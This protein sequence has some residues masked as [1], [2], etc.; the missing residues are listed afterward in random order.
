MDHLIW[1]IYPEMKG[2]KM[3]NKPNCGNI[4]ILIGGKEVSVTEPTVTYDQIMTYTKNGLKSID[5]SGNFPFI[6]FNDAASEPKNGLL[7]PGQEV[8]VSQDD[9]TKFN[10]IKSDIYLRG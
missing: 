8:I 7:S 9:K 2:Q 5:F 3:K 1:G 6:M 10:V 4:L